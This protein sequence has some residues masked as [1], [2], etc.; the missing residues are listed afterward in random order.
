VTIAAVSSQKRQ[1]SAGEELHALVLLATMVV[2]AIV[3]V[4]RLGAN[5]D[6]TWFVVAVLVSWPI[7]TAIHCGVLATKSGVGA[8][9]LGEADITL[10]GFVEALE[11]VHQE[12]L[13]GCTR[14][15]FVVWAQRA[16]A[17]LRPKRF[18]DAYADYVLMAPVAPDPHLRAVA[19]NN[20][21]WA[22]LILG[23]PELR[24]D[25]LDRAQEAVQIEPD[26]TAF[27]GTLAFALLENGKPAESLAAL[28]GF[29]DSKTRPDG[30]ASHLCQRAMAEARLG[31]MAAAARHVREAEALDPENE[32]LDRARAE[33]GAAGTLATSRT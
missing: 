6:W 20:A 30:Q 12:A 19:L 16:G 33:A 8:A 23:N 22:A 4:R 27:L 24:L 32:L 7:E 15:S 28:D 9:V 25:A 1:L 11:P 3:V 5:A 10:E 2:L 21:A 26:Q 14:A 31:D 17:R 18:A 13:V 29:D